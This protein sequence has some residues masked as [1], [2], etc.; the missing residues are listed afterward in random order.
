MATPDIAPYN[1]YIGN[2]VTTEF[3]VGFPY[4][5]KDFVTVYVRR[6]GESQEKMSPVTDWEWVNDT[7]VRFPKAGS[8]LDPLADGEVISICRET[9]LESEY[10]F[11]NQKRL[12]PE[13]VM[14]ADDLEMQINQ[15]QEWRLKRCFGLNQTAAGTETPDLTVGEIVPNRA[16]KWNSEGSGIE[17]SKYDPDEAA[18]E[19]AGS[20]TAAAASAEE[21]ELQA[22][23][24]KWYAENVVFGMANELFESTDWQQDDGKY[25]IFVADKAIICGVYKK[26]GDDYELVKNIDLQVSDEGVT[27]VSMSAFDGFYCLPEAAR[28]QYTFTQVSELDTWVIEH[29]LGKYPSVTLVD[30]NNTVMVGTVHYDSLNQLTVT[31]TEAVSGSAYLN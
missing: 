7:T 1:N 16:L 31:F 12:F 26:V 18:T 22:G 6:D 29:N 4:I 3:S 24:S 13:D 11:T 2:G 5:K 14:D 25:K 10:K 15:E 19:A 20:A 28:T 9:P 27:I 21:A 17:S 23:I 30:D 8:T